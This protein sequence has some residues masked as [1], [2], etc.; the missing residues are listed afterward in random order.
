MLREDYLNMQVRE[1]SHYAQLIHRAAM[2]SV[3]A[4]R[5]P[6]LAKLRLLGAASARAAHSHESS[7]AAPYYTR[8]VYHDHRALPLPDI[9]FHE[10]LSTQEVSLKEKEKG[11]WKQL[12]QEEKISLYRIQFNKTYAEINKPSNE[13]KSVIGGVFFFFGI[14]ALIV[15]WQRVHVFPELPHTLEDDWKAMQAQRMLDM[16]VGPIQGFS[17]NWDYEKKEWKK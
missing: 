2:L 14:T 7:D 13:W 15:W 4:Q 9:P 1:D 12:S 5:S 6:L 8:P 10:S 3:L 11:P 17:S 16:R